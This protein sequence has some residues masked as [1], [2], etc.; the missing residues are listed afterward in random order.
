MKFLSTITCGL[1]LSSSLI[2]TNVQATSNEKSLQAKY[3]NSC[4]QELSEFGAV[5]AEDFRSDGTVKNAHINFRAIPGA[6]RYVCEYDHRTSTSSSHS[7][8]YN[9]KPTDRRVLVPIPKYNGDYFFTFT[10][11]DSN[12]NVIRRELYGYNYDNGHITL[13]LFEVVK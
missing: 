5:L 12:D 6:V 4:K 3:S 1:I 9:I 8:S 10:A 7:Y 2:F 13:Y 11:Y